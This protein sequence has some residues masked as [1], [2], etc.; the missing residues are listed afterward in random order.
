M[1][2]DPA[3]LKKLEWFK[4]RKFGLMMHWGTYSQWGIVES[5][6]LCSEDEPWCQRP[7]DNYMEYVAR[8]ENLQRTFNPV[9]FDPQSW[10]AAA[11]EA[12]MKYMI[13]TTKHHDGFCMYDTKQTHYR[14]TDPDCPF[15]TNPR[16][17]IARELFDAFRALGFGIGAYYSK[18]DWHSPWYWSPYWAH[19]DRNVNYDVTKHPDRWREFCTFTRKQI[20]ELVTGYGPLDILWFDGVWV[21]PASRNQDIDMQGIAARARSH[22]PGILFVDRAVGGPYEDYRTPEQEVP[23]RPLDYP[24]ETCMTMGN[25]WSYKPDDTYKSAGT[26]IHLLVD[27]VAKGGNFLLNIGPDPTGKLPPESLTRLK[28]IGAWIKVNG[29]AIYETRPIAPYKEG[30]ICYTRSRNGVIYAI[31]LA[32]ENEDQIPTSIWLQTITPRPQSRIC[33]LGF[34]EPLRWEKN[35][36]GVLIRI[37]PDVAAAPPCKHAWTFAIED[38]EESKAV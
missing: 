24:W 35:G 7:T 20:D 12:G 10:A 33:L 5:W 17:D 14:I 8:Y 9:E 29:S 25:S 15:H 19:A 31:Y 1:E 27:I 18:P 21:Q 22:T 13:F 32:R 16:A 3:V 34:K 11:H 36:K 30:S 2:K 38:P 37:P 23:E 28:Q 6:T 26:L 4:D